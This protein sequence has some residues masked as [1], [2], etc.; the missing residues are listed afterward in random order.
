[1]SRMHLGTYKNKKK[2]TST[3]FGTLFTLLLLLFTGST[4]WGLDTAEIE[5]ELLKRFRLEPMEYK[6]RRYLNVKV[7][8]DDVTEKPL[9]R[10]CNEFIDENQLLAGYFAQRL[11]DRHFDNQS[12]TDKEKPEAERINAFDAFVQ[13][14]KQ[15]LEPV[16]WMFGLFLESKGHPINMER[17]PV[18]PSYTWVQIKEI[19][20]RN[21]HIKEI[22]PGGKPRVKVCVAGEGF[23]DLPR[24][25]R[26]LLL[27]A[28]TFQAMMDGLQEETFGTGVYECMAVIEKLNLSPQ[29]G[30]DLRKAREVSREILLKDNQLETLLQDVYNKKKVYLPFEIKKK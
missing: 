28:F 18:K 16:L 9:A 24:P 6:G 4:L 7:V 23:L 1:M 8:K 22:L 21:V 25:Q 17:Q 19:A 15:T 2:K 13:T 20:V 12:E 30:D 29:R 27:E 11:F 5:T 10:L 3:L 26:N 14:N